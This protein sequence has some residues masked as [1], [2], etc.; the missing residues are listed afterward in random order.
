MISYFLLMSNSQ[1]KDRAFA[2][3]LLTKPIQKNLNWS[4]DPGT[5]NQDD[6]SLYIYLILGSWFLVLGS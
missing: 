2:L 4:Q 5:R 3:S 6:Y 1:K